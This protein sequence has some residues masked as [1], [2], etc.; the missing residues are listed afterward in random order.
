MFSSSLHGFVS[1]QWIIKYEIFLGCSIRMFLLKYIKHDLSLLVSFVDY[2]H[3][4]FLFLL[5]QQ[6][7][8]HVNAL[9]NVGCPN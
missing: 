6:S 7:F 2:Y 9:E 4:R 3:G 5:S 1:F 8:Y